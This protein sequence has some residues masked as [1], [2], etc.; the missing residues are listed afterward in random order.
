MIVTI[1]VEVV[2]VKIDRFRTEGFGR[3][4]NVKVVSLLKEA[5]V[6]IGG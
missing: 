5:T 2:S 4:S 3:V 1:R 6:T